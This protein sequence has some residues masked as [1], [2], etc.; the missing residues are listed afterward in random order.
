MS[1]SHK[2]PQVSPQPTTASAKPK[3]MTTH[4]ITE[5]A[6]EF[7]ITTRTIRFYEDEHLL[8]PVRNGRS[9]IYS[10][11]D[12]VRLQLVLRGRRLGFSLSEIREIMDMYDADPGEAGQLYYFLSKIEQRR[13]I[14]KK[15]RKDILVTLR[16][17]DAI[18]QQCRAQLAKTKGVNPIA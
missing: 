4:T 3:P 11:R 13:S 12:R 5:L 15:Q 8:A 1:D 9:R 16:E 2:N 18:E 17:L 6:R 7:D 10:N 14:L